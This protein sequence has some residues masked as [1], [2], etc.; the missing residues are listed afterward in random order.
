MI[1]L[2]ACRVVYGCHNNPVDDISWSKWRELA[3]AAFVAAAALTQLLALRCQ[4]QQYVVIQ[5][6]NIHAFIRHIPKSRRKRIFDEDRSILMCPVR[7]SYTRRTHYCNTKSKSIWCF[8]HERTNEQ[9]AIGDIAIEAHV[10]WCVS[11]AYSKAKLIWRYLMTKFGRKTQTTASQLEISIATILQ[12]KMAP[13]TNSEQFQK[14][15]TIR[16]LEKLEIGLVLNFLFVSD[17]IKCQLS[18]SAV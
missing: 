18:T 4:K 16:I 3:D 11:V 12:F 1:F 10:I 15:Q 8:I 5:L 9:K 13:T 2:N 7:G 14:K 6:Y 17:G